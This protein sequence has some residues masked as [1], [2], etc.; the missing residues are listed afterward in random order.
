MQLKDKVAVVTG[1]GRGLG[2]A[3]CEALAAEGALVVAA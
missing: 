3:Y 1:G 2:R